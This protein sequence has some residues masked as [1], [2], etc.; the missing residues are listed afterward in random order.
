VKAAVIENSNFPGSPNPPALAKAAIED[1]VR[2]DVTLRPMTFGTLGIVMA[3]DEEAANVVIAITAHNAI[4]EGE[5]KLHP[6]AIARSVIVK[7]NPRPGGINLGAHKGSL[8]TNL[9]P[10][11]MSTIG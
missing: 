5:V 1:I 9:S 8:A 3:F 2:T 10:S 11:Q 4:R 6:V 7:T